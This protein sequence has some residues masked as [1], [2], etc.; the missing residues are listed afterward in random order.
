[1]T[2]IQFGLVLPSGPRKPMGREPFLTALRTNLDVVQE[3]FASVWCIDHVQFKD[4]PLL[5]GWTM[6]TY[7]AAQYPQFEYGHLVLCQSFRNPALLAKM[8]ATFQYLSGGH[9]ILGIGAGWLEEEY[10]AY[11][12]PFPPA[13]T[14][15]EELDETLQIIK[16][17]W[18]D[19]QA[20][21]KGQHYQVENAYCEPK[22]RPIPPILVGGRKPRMLRLIARHA[23]WWNL[24]HPSLEDYRAL[25]P[26]CEQACA[27]VGRD[28]ATLRRTWFG[29]CLCVPPGTNLDRIDTERLRKRNA[30]LGT[31]E[32]IIEQMQAFIDL[33]VDYFMIAN[34]NF[35]DQTSLEL[36]THEVLP[37]INAGR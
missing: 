16:A 29:Q 19:E 35:P 2:R 10:K 30:L 28:P 37:R 5:E 15:V 17:L 3:H 13:G 11:G 36:L 18:R 31:P 14:R 12:Y 34:S 26:A 23:D 32:Q 24:S 25:I 1:M 7:M 8:A 9:F 21:V 33:G 27:E 22:P 20:T 4:D 6:L